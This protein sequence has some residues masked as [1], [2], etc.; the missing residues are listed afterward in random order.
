MDKSRD[1]LSLNE[2]DS[3]KSLRTIRGSHATCCDYVAFNQPH[4]HA[5]AASGSGSSSGKGREGGNS[6]KGGKGGNS[7]KAARAETMQRE[8]QTRH[9]RRP[10]CQLI[11]E[12]H[13]SRTS[14]GL[15]FK[16]LSVVCRSTVALLPSPTAP[17]ERF[18]NIML[19][20]T[21]ISGQIGGGMAP[22]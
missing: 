11:P 22:T 16:P 4:L 15:L 2:E 1:E 18:S 3:A 5:I 19:L 17:C 7:A 13:R 10:A 20:G 8:G 9:I 14:T 6:G 12:K 21:P